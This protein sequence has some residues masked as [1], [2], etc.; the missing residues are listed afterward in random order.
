MTPAMSRKAFRKDPA[1]PVFESDIP[2][3]QIKGGNSYEQDYR[4]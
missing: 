1:D 2:K 3:E 4:Y